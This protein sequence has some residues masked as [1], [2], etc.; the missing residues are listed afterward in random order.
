LLSRFSSETRACLV[1]EFVNIRPEDF[2]EFKV[3][4]LTSPSKPLNAPGTDHSP[5]ELT[6]QR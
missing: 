6:R 5:I 1:P 3:G 4:D 2:P